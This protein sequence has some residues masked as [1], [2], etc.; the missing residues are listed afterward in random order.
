MVPKHC[1]NHFTVYEVKVSYCTPYTVLY[2]NCILI[3]LEEKY[4]CREL[5]LIDC[6]ENQDENSV[7]K[8]NSIGDKM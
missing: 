8:L 3:K 6:T 4:I 7:L 2:V 5:S 1:D